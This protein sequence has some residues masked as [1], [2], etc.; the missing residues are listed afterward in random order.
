MTK[1]TNP[2]WTIY[3]QQVFQL[4]KQ[5]FPE[6]K[7][8]RNVHVKGR[9]SRRMRQI[10]ILIA[11]KTPAGMQKTVVDTKL[12][13]RK[14]DIKAVDAL[15]GFVE[16]I[17][18][19]RGMLITTRGYT[20]GALRRA[21]YGPSDLE[22]DIL[23]FSALR[24]FQGF[25]AIPYAGEHSFLVPAPFGWVID[26]TRREG[27]IACMYQRG[28]D[29]ETAIK[30]NEIIYINFWNRT[31]DRITAEKLDRT[32]VAR[33]KL[34][35]PVTVS[36]RS[37]RQRSDAVT[38]LRVVRA[39]RY[40]CLEVTGFLE[41]D[42]VIFFAVLLTPYETQIPNIRRLESVLRRAVPV[43]VRRDNTAIVVKLQGELKQD[44]S[45]RERAQLLR[46]LGYWYRDMGQ[47]E[48]AQ[49]PLEE[50]LVI[51]PENRYA[52]ISELFPALAK[53]KDSNRGKEVIALLL[54][55]DPHNPTVFNDSLTLGTDWLT[56]S[57][58][59]ELIENLKSEMPGDQL[60]Q[61]NCDLYAG[62]LL[63]NLNRPAAKRRFIAAREAFLRVVPR[64]HEVF[65]ALRR[66]LAQCS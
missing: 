9:Y 8:R 22:L 62:S 15:A 12:F 17:G 47:F 58:L 35:G 33:M 34:S 52:T 48:N 11:E 66:A 56:G 29:L 46:E 43:K 10:D 57:D 20:R 26:A 3:E 19:Q 37:T 36:Y 40:P 1:P 16:D 30:K 25:G 28:L 65:G 13:K 38:R 55:L 45:P 53:L 27:W 60:V 50:S 64:K 63:M 51:D 2:Q 49:Q 44:H 59:L 31:D 32:Q 42:D 23:D 41:F 14:V 7:I 39:R 18:A 21:F 5:Q 24:R 6:A 54:R 4:F 61:A